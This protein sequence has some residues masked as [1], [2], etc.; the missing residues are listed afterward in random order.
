MPTTTLLC[1]INQPKQQQQQRCSRENKCSRD[2]IDSKRTSQNKNRITF[3]CNIVYINII[4]ILFFSFW[5][6]FNWE[7][8]LL[9][10][11]N[12]DNMNEQICYHDAL[13]LVHDIDCVIRI[14]L[15][16]KG[17]FFDTFSVYELTISSFIWVVSIHERLSKVWLQAVM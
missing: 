11:H 6:N 2:K 12:I 14:H 5:L 15:N 16:R 17:N 1:N 4:S 9:S 10:Q 7:Q 13:N 8:I 3:F